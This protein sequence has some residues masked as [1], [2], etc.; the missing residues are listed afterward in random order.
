MMI[1]VIFFGK[2]PRKKLTGL[3]RK[4]EIDNGKGKQR[5][6]RLFSAGYMNCGGNTGLA[7]AATVGR[8]PCAVPQALAL[9]SRFYGA[10]QGQILILPAAKQ[11]KINWSDP[12]R[13]IPR[14]LFL[15]THK[16][17]HESRAPAL[18]ISSA[19]HT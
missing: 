16:V 15:K 8:L 6:Q 19:D 3:L 2:Q 7:T 18:R 14:S 17:V 1:S 10:R 11:G 4:L 12:K 13:A 5:L 9:G